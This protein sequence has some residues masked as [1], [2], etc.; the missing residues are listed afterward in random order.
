MRAKIYAHRARTAPISSMRAIAFISQ[1]FPLYSER[2]FSCFARPPLDYAA[3]TR[4]K[5]VA[6]RFFA[7]STPCVNRRSSTMPNAGSSNSLNPFNYFELICNRF[8]A[9][10]PMYTNQP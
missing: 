5:L 9:D 10:K 4:I 1:N 6:G 3:I 2:I 8:N 7:R